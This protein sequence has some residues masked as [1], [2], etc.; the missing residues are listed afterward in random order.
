MKFSLERY[1]FHLE[2][3]CR[4]DSD[5]TRGTPCEIYARLQ[6][7]LRCEERPLKMIYTAAADH[8]AIAWVRYYT[9]T[10]LNILSPTKMFV[11]NSIFNSRTERVIYFNVLSLTGMLVNRSIFNTRTEWILQFFII[12]FPEIV[13]VNRCMFQ[14]FNDGKSF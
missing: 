5:E 14:Q 8:A 13:F 7:R 2:L 10:Y 6:Q 4:Y 11:N 1:D 9:L 12:P 3:V